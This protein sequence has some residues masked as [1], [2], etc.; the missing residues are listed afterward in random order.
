M[1]NWDPIKEQWVKCYKDS[2]FCLSETTNNR[3]ESTFAKIKGV[4]TRFSSLHQFFEEFFIVLGVLRNEQNNQFLKAISKRDNCLV[5]EDEI[6]FSKLVTPYTLDFILKAKERA[7][8]KNY[9]VLAN[10]DVNFS[11]KSGLSIYNC[12]IDTCTCNFMKKMK[13][14]FI[15]YFLFANILVCPCFMMASFIIDGQCPITNRALVLDLQK[16]ATKSIHQ[17]THTITVVDN[18]SSCNETV[19]TQGQKLKKITN[20]C[21]EI[22]SVGCEGVMKVFKSRYEELQN[23]LNRWPMQLFTWR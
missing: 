21:Q 3:I 12:T 13:L 18:S 7:N 9:H 16:R 22:I 6:K 8:N 14:P 11:V 15:T 23:L 5:D 1:T 17:G 4:C 2:Y 10:D 19:L 20:L